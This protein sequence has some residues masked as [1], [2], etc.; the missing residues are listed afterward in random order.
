MRQER[1]SQPISALCGGGDVG[2][3]GGGAELSPL[4][5]PNASMSRRGGRKVG[6]GRAGV[7]GSVLHM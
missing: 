3:S 4:Q 6:R 1:D 2:C 5:P 7:A